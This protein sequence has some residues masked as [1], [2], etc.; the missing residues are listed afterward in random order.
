MDTQNVVHLLAWHNWYN[1][2]NVFVRVLLPKSINEH[3]TVA[4]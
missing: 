4:S 2:L 1:N 3:T